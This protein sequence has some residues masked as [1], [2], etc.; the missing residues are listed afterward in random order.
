MLVTANPMPILGDEFKLIPGL[1]LKEEFNDNLLLGSTSRRSDFVTTLTP[2][3]EISGASER[4]SMSLSTG[5]N[6][7]DYASNT[8]LD[9]VDFFVQSGF[10]YRYD[11][12]LAFSVGAGYVQDSRPDRI[13]LNGLA[14]KTGSDRQN[15]QLSGSY[16]VSEK[17]TS[18]VSYAYS[19][20]AFDN[21]GFLTTT[22]HSATIGQDYDLDRYLRQA[23]LVGNL[24]Y[25]RSITDT[26][27]VDNYS[28]T[29]GLTKKIHE[30]WNVS[31]NVGGRYTH[32]EFDATTSIPPA[33]TISSDDQGWIGNLSLN[34]NGEKTNA[35][36]AFK[37]DVIPASGRSGT[38]ERTEITTNL[39]QKFSRELSGSFGL[40]SSWIKSNQNQ[41]SAQTIDENNLIINSGLRYDFSDYVSLEGNY[42]FLAIFYGN[43]A[44]VNQNVFMLRLT[45]R[46]DL[47]DL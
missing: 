30:L 40:G 42:R 37:H 36:L 21:P 14:L 41:L 5:I 7:L 29:L 27:L 1:A 18:S 20:E 3:L 26:S 23:K 11:P 16:A 13:D 22:V 32:S 2:S 12:R 15:Y 47:M 38:T 28:L 10:N 45:M 44:Q 17:S 6:W 4:R 8:G 35:S 46:H 9:S 24:G 19:Q 39:N 31:F 25:F 33:Q 43:S 34:Y